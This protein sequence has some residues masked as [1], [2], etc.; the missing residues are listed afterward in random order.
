MHLHR[1]PF[2]RGDAVHHGVA[3]RTVRPDH[4]AAQHT[5]AHGAQALDRALRA[6]VQ[7]VGLELDAQCSQVL[8]GM[9]QEEQLAL[10]VHGRAL[11][12]R[13]D[14]GPT[15]LEP[16]VLAADVE[17]ARRADRARGRE[18][19]DR[20]WELR[21]VAL[22]G[23]R[24]RDVRTNVLQV[25]GH[26][27]RQVA[28]DRFV[29]A[30]V[31]ER[32]R[33]VP[34]ERLEPHA[35]SDQGDGS[36]VHLRE[37]TATLVR[38]SHMR[39][40]STGA[41]I[42]A[43]AA[44]ATAQTLPLRHYDVPEGLTN[45]R[46]NC[47]Y[48]DQRG[49]LWIGTWEGL[50]R[51]DGVE[52]VQFGTREGL[53]S[54]YVN[55][56]AE[57]SAGRMW[58]AS[59]DGSLALF[60]GER[61]STSE[62]SLAFR[63]FHLP[64]HPEGD[65][66]R[67][68]CA[69]PRSGVWC[70]TGVGLYH[71]ELDEHGELHT[72]RPF[73]TTMVA[74][75]QAIVTSPDGHTWFGSE[76]EVIELDGARTLHHPVPVGADLGEL[77]AL[78]PASEGRLL[79]G[80]DRGLYELGPAAADGVRPWTPVPLVGLNH[81]R[82]LARDRDGEVWIGSWQG[83]LR[84]SAGEMTVM[85]REHGLADDSIRALC[86][87][88]DGNLWIGTW[89]AGIARL[90]SKAI[91]H[92]TAENG[93]PDRTALHMVEDPRGRIVV[94][95][96][97]TLARIDGNRVE[98]I[99]GSDARQWSGVGQ[100]LCY[101]SRGDA[102]IG[103][104]DKHFYRVPGPDL[105]LSRA[106]AIGPAEGF[107]DD[108][109][110]GTPYEDRA[111][112]LWVATNAGELA[113]YDREKSP[114]HIHFEHARLAP[115]PNVAL[116]PRWMLRVRS[117]ELWLA[118]YDGLARWID[119]HLDP[120]EL[121][122]HAPPPQ[123]RCLYQDHASNLWVGTRHAGVWRTRD[124]AATHPTFERVPMGE[125]LISQAVWSIAEDAHGRLYLGTGRG[126]DRIDPETGS[127]VHIGS[128]E[129]LAGEIVTHCIT[130]RHGRIWVATSGGVS[131][132]DPEIDDPT[133]AP[134]SVWI[135]TVRVAGEEVAIDPRGVREVDAGVHPASENDVEIRFTAP[136]FRGEST[137][138]FQYRLQGVDADWSPPGLQRSVNYARLDAGSYRF[139][140]RA[141]HAAG[142]ESPWNAQVAF[143]IRPPFWRSWWFVG[144]CTGVAAA[145]AF[146]VHRAKVKRL[147]A[148]ERIRTQIATDIHDDM[149][150]GLAQ[151]AILSE[152]AKRQGQ[153]T[154]R[155]HMDEIA[156][157]ARGMRDS[158][159]DIVWSIDPSK[160]HFVDLVQRMRQVTFNLLEAEGVS[161]EFDAPGEAEMASVPLGPDR[162]RHVLLMFKELVS[163]VARHAG[164]SRVGV[165]IRLTQEVL[166]LSV[167]DDGCGFDTGARAHGHGLSGLRRRAEGLNAEVSIESKRGAGTKAVVVIRI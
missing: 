10:G 143:T 119:G 98:T 27:P 24:P 5:L 30:R 82:A 107:T 102:W 149:G 134:P 105:D 132:L 90:S 44:V 76:V 118:P 164:A 156:R 67:A 56:L 23:L 9:A 114:D 65:L 66:I 151:I 55:A 127:V 117:G 14:P 34:R 129:G 25:G 7:V 33:V 142:V 20:E 22:A 58:V 68:L 158:M 100:R 26:R 95:F 38:R 96:A 69:D 152:V 115:S 88:S 160:D 133:P 64:E 61:R 41:S 108:G 40:K 21:A 3:N 136:C 59:A 141:V 73:P 78:V 122:P 138:A 106:Q 154:A 167:E 104:E 70:A 97:R 81:L 16:A 8:E 49:Y 47:L 147:L 48:Q 43:T 39:W 19:D 101:D 92:W 131:R 166:R 46:V 87:D 79:A 103:T 84:W 37:P 60:L 120:L 13:R 83:L 123:S 42:I 130:D 32:A 121:E 4:V 75:P 86:N 45:S 12:L 91:V 124:P 18:I 80:F 74:W 71:V 28:P 163:N 128:R 144:S 62:P 165:E 2:R 140:V 153:E 125:G 50:S 139:Q 109:V 6:Q 57:D 137:L 35:A 29:A 110:F 54:D 94:A 113:W 85:R 93:L 161:V 51:F 36:R 135:T 63:R 157:L 15:D 145:V 162:R 17:V 53:G 52:F 99:T 77:V 31:E 155:S 89:S 126:V 116:P 148:L 1:R 111:G 72:E 11:V 146:V 150:S 112:T 159:S